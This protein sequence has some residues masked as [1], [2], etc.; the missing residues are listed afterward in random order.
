MTTDVR[1]AQ[2]ST[3]DAFAA[4]W[5]DWHARREEELRAPHGWL[6]L[7]ALHWL[8]ETPAEYPPLPGEWS[9]TPETGVTLSAR[10]EDG[11]RLDG[12]LVSGTVR[13]APA[14]NAAGALATVGDL[15]V[16][17]IRRGRSHA[18]RVRDPQAATRTGFT[19]VPAYAPDPAW[20]V[21][22]TL[23]PLPEPREITVDAV[24]AGLHHRR[25]AVGTVRFTAAGQE[26]TLT[27][28]AGPD[29]ASLVLHFRDAT[30]GV[31]TAPNARTLTIPA[32][33]ADGR[34]TIDFNRAVNLPCAFT[35]FATCPLPPAENRLPIAVEAGERN[36]R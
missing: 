23:T 8:D 4:E 9:A 25:T 22:G 32:A 27:A 11:V 17:I 5:A 21:A 28:L 36:P 26:H 3:D 1:P 18:L 7:T 24:V 31:T 19:G 12:T 6:S 10:A 20:V 30:N 16:E 13:V 33:D 14:D 29:D 15:R 35:D 2:S 34:V